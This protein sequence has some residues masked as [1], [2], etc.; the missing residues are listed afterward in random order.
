MEEEKSFNYRDRLSLIEQMI[1]VAKDEHRVKGDSWLIWGWLLFVCSIASAVLFKT[2]LA[3]Y[4]GWIWMSMLVVGIVVFFLIRRQGQKE[5]VTYVQGLLRK[6][7][8]GFFI[9]LLVTIAASNVDAADN[10]AKNAFPFGYFYILY[11]FW[12]FIYGSAIKFR[13]LLIGAIVNWAAAL[14]IFLTPDFFYKMIISSAA[15]MVGYLI[16]GYMLRNQFKK[17]YNAKPESI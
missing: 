13:P 2:G 8:A 14:A 1:A 5:V 9:S 7:S 6:F 3:D 17:S 12:M 10:S 4:I 15:I 11:A 16:P